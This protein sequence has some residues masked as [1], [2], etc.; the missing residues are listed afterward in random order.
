MDERKSELLTRIIESYILSGVPVGSNMLVE[1]YRLPFSS[2]TVRNEMAALEALGYMV[3]PH[4]SAGRIPTERAYRYYVQSLKPTRL[5]KL[6]QHALATLTQTARR[7]DEDTRFKGFARTLAKLSGEIAFV[8]FEG[9]HTF[10]AGFSTLCDKPEFED[11]KL[12]AALSRLIETLDDIIEDIFNEID[13]IPRIWVGRYQALAP[14]C[15]AILV[16]AQYCGSNGIIGI[17]GP[18]RMHYSKNKA[19]LETAKALLNEI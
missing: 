19:I 15:S 18:M 6:Q 4:T 8:A 13:D 10:V 2:A 14:Q 12:V 17:I 1:K 9:S 7:N 11:R 16:R 3:Q 5:T